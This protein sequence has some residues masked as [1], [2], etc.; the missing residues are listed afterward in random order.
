MKFMKNNV[1]PLKVEKEIFI[2]Y[3]KKKYL[4]YYIYR[5]K[6]SYDR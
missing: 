6:L 1:K 2:V 3:K 4:K 5:K